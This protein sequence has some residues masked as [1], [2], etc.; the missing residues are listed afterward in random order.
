MTALS[1]VLWSN[2]ESRN[3]KDFQQ[4]LE[5]LLP[6]F[7]KLDWNYSPGSF[8]VEILPGKINDAGEIEVELLSEQSRL[9]IRYTGDGSEPNA[10]SEKYISKIKLIKDAE[11]RAALFDGEDRKGRVVQRD[12]AFHRALGKKTSYQMQYHIRYTAGGDQALV[13][14][15]LGAENFRDGTWQ[16]FEGN[17]LELTIDLGEVTDVFRTELNFLQSTGSWIFMP[18]YMEVSLSLDGENWEVIQRVNNEVPD[19]LQELTIQRLTADFPTQ[20]ARFI[21]VLA[22]NRGVCPDWHPGAGSSSWIFCDEVI[23]R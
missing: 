10:N 23:V 8:L 14:G 5:S 4:R 6:R 18:E 22:K 21:Q 17:D 9:D 11:V 20:E 15:I 12:F 3:W 1:E 13:D 2:K 7:E 19:D 16:G